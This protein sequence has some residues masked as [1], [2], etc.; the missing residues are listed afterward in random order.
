MNVRKLRQLRTSGKFEAEVSALPA[1]AQ[2]HVFEVL[3]R[4]R[5]EE[6][7]PGGDDVDEILPP[8]VPAGWRRA[9]PTTD[10]WV[11]YDLSKDGDFVSLRTVRV[12]RTLSPEALAALEDDLA[13][14]APTPYIRAV[15]AP[16]DPEGAPPAV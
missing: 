15:P 16:D 3:R 4:L 8:C 9:V 7:L 10:L 1:S 13:R 14:R 6:E 2:E 11:F 12:P 5:A